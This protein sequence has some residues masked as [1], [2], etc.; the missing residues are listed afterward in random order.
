MSVSIFP[1]SLF[2]SENSILFCYFAN[3]VQEGSITIFLLHFQ[4]FSKLKEGSV[5]TTKQA[6]TQQFCQHLNSGFL[7]IDSLSLY[8]PVLNTSCCLQ[9]SARAKKPPGGFTSPPHKALSTSTVRRGK[10]LLPARI[11][12]FSVLISDQILKMA[13]LPSTCSSQKILYPTVDN[14]S[15]ASNGLLFQP[16][17]QNFLHSKFFP[18]GLTSAT[19]SKS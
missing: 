6:C 2:V 15:P 17:R 14:L 1:A 10:E 9:A 11:T 8:F 18:S 19:V 13:S 3:A 12:G 5:Q 16:S 7:W 4:H